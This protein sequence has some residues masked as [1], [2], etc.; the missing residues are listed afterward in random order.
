MFF[1]FVCEQRKNCGPIEHIPFFELG[2]MVN[3]QVQ[4]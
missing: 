3:L 2:I 4:D 1:D